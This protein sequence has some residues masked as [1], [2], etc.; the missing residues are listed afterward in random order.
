[1][2]RKESTCRC[3][4]S[5]TE[6]KLDLY[7][8]SSEV[9]IDA[10]NIEDPQNFVRISECFSRITTIKIS[11]AKDEDTSKICSQCLSDLKFCFLFQRKCLDTEK[12]Y[13]RPL[14]KKGK[15]LHS[16]IF[17]LKF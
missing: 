11:D 8:F 7:D 4:L 5:E 2:V 15:Y 17:E 14:A 10:D 16:L 13:S 6:S 9:S 3:C 1:M 12:V